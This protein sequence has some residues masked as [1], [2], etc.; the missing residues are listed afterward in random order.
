LGEPSTPIAFADFKALMGDIPVPTRSFTPRVADEVTDALAGSYANSFKLIVQKTAAGRGCAQ[1]KKVIEEQATLSEPMWRAG[2]SVAK[3]CMDGDKAIHKI[4]SKHPD[5]SPEETEE[6]AAQIRGP[7]T[8]DK[9]DEF[10]PGVCGSCEFRGRFKSPIVLGREVQEA[11]EEDS[12]VEDVPENADTPKQTYV[13]PKYP[14]PFFRGKAGGIFKRTKNKEGDPIEVPVYHNDFYVV[15]RL[16]D[17]DAGESVMIRLHLPKDGVRE[18]TVPLSSI[19]SRDEFR[20]HMAA[21]GVAVMKMEELMA[22]TTSWVNKL[23]ATAQAEEAHR[24]FGWTDETMSSFVLGNK[25]IRADRVDH[26]PPASSTAKMF[27]HFYS[28]GTM[29]GWKKIMDFYNRPGMEMHQYVIGLS[30]GSPLMQ[31]VPQCASLFHVH[32]EDTGLGKTTAMMAGA[33]IWGNPEQM[34]LREVDTHATKMN[35]AEIYKNVFLGVD[36][37]TNVHPKEASDFLYQ[38]T[39]GSQR[40][41]MTQNANQERTRGETWHTNAYST[42]N[43]SL[44]ARVRIYKAIPKAE[45]TRVLEYEAQKFHFD[46]KAETDELGQAM[47]AHYGHA[48]VPYMQYVIANLAEVRE[49]F[50]ST[51]ARID[52]AAG[53]TQ[54]HRF[55]SVQAASG[56][57]GLLIAK[58]LGLIN[59]KISDVVTW[60]LKV[61]VK[62]KQ[63]VETMSGTLEDILTGYLAENYN[64]ILRI[65]STV[66]ARMDD[67][68]LEHIITPDA[69]PRVVLVGRYEYDV[70][71]LY[72]LPKPLRDWCSKQQINYQ[73]FVDGLRTGSTRAVR[74]K[75]RMGKG[76]NMNL[77]PSDAI[78]IDCTE[79]M[80]EEVE[81]TLVSHAAIVSKP[82]VQQAY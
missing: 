31:F 5:Y 77:P 71:L 22:Y 24:Q 82:P 7:Y 17:P 16:S 53:L 8:C 28:K 2:L 55:W 49:L 23:Q 38:L 44:L 59:F 11:T 58:R 9:F 34:L 72:L 52:K 14:E 13:I 54:P 42:G 57:S 26:N 80:S 61:I 43:T 67:K 65:K 45:A 15:R 64:N 63:E 25:E 81:Q 40:N 75:V 10:N 70:K 68:T 1:I 69:S 56:I 79:F 32:S 51:Q 12:V 33:S 47:Y 18:F 21:H 62:A 73:T 3:F 46:T 37:M 27:P 60:L 29:E 76:T 66:D 74:R 30:F 50:M 19:L 4:S 6:K 78:V 39:S 35:R 36:E 41:R 20:K 48:C